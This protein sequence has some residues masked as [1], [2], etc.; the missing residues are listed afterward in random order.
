M[1][2]PVYDRPGMGDFLYFMKFTNKNSKKELVQNIKELKSLEKQGFITLH[3]DTGQKVKT[4][5]GAREITAWYIDD[6]KAYAFENGHA[7]FYSI[8]YLAGCFYPFV[9]KLTGGEQI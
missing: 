6:H 9:F 5:D 2:I 1:R 7:S 4:L 3:E 8:E